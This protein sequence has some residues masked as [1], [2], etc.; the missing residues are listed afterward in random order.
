MNSNSIFQWI[1][2]SRSSIPSKY[3]NPKIVYFLLLLSLCVDKLNVTGAITSYFSLAE[4]SNA[5]ASTVTWVL[6]GYSLTLGAFIIVFGKVADT[7]GVHIVFVLGTALMAIFSLLAAVVNNII[8]VIVFRAF[9]G[10]AGA[11]LVPSGFALTANYFQG[12]ARLVALKLLSIVLMASYGIGVIFGGAFSETNVGYKGFFYLTFSLSALSS[13]LLY[14]IIIPVERT[15]AHKAMKIKN[16]DFLG[17]VLLIAGLLLIILGF[18]EA[19]K[20]WKSPTVYVC[21]PVGFALVL[22]MVLFENVYIRI[23][24]KRKEAQHKVNGKERTAEKILGN[25]KSNWK[26][27]MMLLFPYELFHIA[28]FGQLFLGILFI[29]A[30]FI[31]V[32]TSLIEY[33]EYVNRESPILASVKVLPVS[34]GLILGALSFNPKVEKKLGV[35]GTLIIAALLCLGGTI[36]VTRLDYNITNSFWKFEFVSQLLIGYGL[37]L[38]FIVFV[39]GLMAQTPLHLQGVVSAV[40][41]AVSQVAAS[42]ST[43]V[44]SSIIGSLDIDDEINDSKHELASRFRNALYFAMALSAGFLVCMLLLKEPKKL[45]PKDSDTEAGTDD[46]KTENKG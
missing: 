11:A 28:N 23:Y 29:N 18:T 22:V 42:L 17:V 25:G 36:W 9:Q 4:K 21:I 39:H 37:N 41:Q 13:I 10:I 40:F 32:Q 45:Q 20:S 27:D 43:A 19:S 15:E 44:L 5:S 14:F 46:N 8:A 38:F 31:A 26:L 2:A 30:T 1:V 35:K 16:L 24:Q 6:S 12:S 7:V 34:V 3:R 33:Y